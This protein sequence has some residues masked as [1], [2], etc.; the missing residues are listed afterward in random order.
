MALSDPRPSEPG[1]WL[2]DTSSGALQLGARVPQR[3]IAVGGVADYDDRVLVGS[4][5]LDV[6]AVPLDG[7]PWRVVPGE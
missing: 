2:S 1:R 4:Q 3:A 6:L 7:P 5:T